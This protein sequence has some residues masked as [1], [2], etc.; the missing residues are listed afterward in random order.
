M[1]EA[2]SIA[3][4]LK[5]RK[6]GGQWSCRC[7]SLSHKGDDKTPP[8][9]G[10]PP[11]QRDQRSPIIFPKLSP[12]G[13]MSPVF[14][15]EGEKDVETLEALSGHLATTNAGGATSWH[16]DLNQYL[17]GLDVVIVPDADDAGEKRI[18]QLS[19]TWPALHPASR[20]SSRRGWCSRQ[21]TALISPTGSR[22]ATPTKNLQNRPRTRRHMSQARTSK[23]NRRDLADSHPVG[24]ARS[25]E[26]FRRAI[27]LRK[28]L[29]P[30]IRFGGLWRTR[31]RKSSK[32][33]VEALAM[34][35]AGPAWHQAGPEV[36]GLVLERG[37]SVGG[38]RP[39]DCGYLPALRIKPQELDGYLFVDSGRATPIVIAEQAK[40]GTLIADPV[41]EALKDA[42]KA[43]EIDVMILDPF[44]SC[45]RVAE[46]DN[47]AI[48]A[49]V[50]K[51][52][53]IADATECSIDLEH[54]IRKTNGKRRRSMT[55]GVPVR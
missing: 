39:Q 19:T 8:A 28:A 5:G 53:E 48:D 45:H 15:P 33:L 2:E 9:H 7:P 13:G 3:R 21:I 31:W 23:P 27:S 11:H 52:A 55:A 30:E 6:S 24:M 43:R 1:S 41:V 37:R 29:Y 40:T 38:N 47:P 42:I 26:R 17:A 16:K 54:H 22:T 20:S 35:R 14:I 46:N 25:K 18:G 32:R 10:T 50:K 36:Q 44:V 49:V 51:F 4:A 34:A 12:P